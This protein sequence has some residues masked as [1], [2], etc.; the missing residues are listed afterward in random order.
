[1]SISSSEYLPIGLIFGSSLIGALWSLFNAFAVYS[2]K[3]KGAALGEDSVE[4]NSRDIGAL[5]TIGKKIE[6]GAKEFLKQEYTVML[7]FVFFFSFVVFALVDYFGNTGPATL[8]FYAT[9]SYI[10]GSLT[11]IA[12]G[13]IGCQL[14]FQQTIV[15]HT[16]QLILSQTHLTALIKQVV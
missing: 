9:I 8:R 7:I 5:E 11:S 13:Y 6:R 1:M 16:K 12:C 2:V 10:L 15:L 3:L 4:N 14:L